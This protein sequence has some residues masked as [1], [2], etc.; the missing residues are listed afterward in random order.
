MTVFCDN[1]Y[2]AY[3]KNGLCTKQQISI[4]NE[5]CD[6]YVHY[7]EVHKD[8]YCNKFYKAVKTKNN[9]PAKAL[10]ENGRKVL[11]KGLIFYTESKVND[12]DDN[13]VW[14]TEEVS[15]LGGNLKHIME[16]F[17]L[18]KKAITKAP[19]I[20]DLPLAMKNENDEWEIVEGEETEQEVIQRTVEWLK[21]KECEDESV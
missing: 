16:R 8:K 19:K 15:G 4:E 2:C 6:D 11:Y 7:Q 9:I 14:V 13:D 3:E 21:K 17:D 12:D 5:T 10:C 1:Y 20:S 18:A